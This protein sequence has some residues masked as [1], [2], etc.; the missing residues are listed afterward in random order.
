[1]EAGSVRQ[2]GDLGF[3][4]SSS[5]C[6][7]SDFLFHAASR[8]V[9]GL[10][11]PHIQWVTGFSLDKAAGAW[12]RQVRLV[13][14]LRMH[15]AIPPPSHASSWRW[16]VF[17]HQGQLAIGVSFLYEKYLWSGTNWCTLR[18]RAYALTQTVSFGNAVWIIW[19][20]NTCYEM[21]LLLNDV[22]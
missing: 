18:S 9:L 22:Y 1:M 14:S 6:T 19:H 4:L 20:W 15:G 10:T 7:D 3:E 8:P 5:A 21:Y 11:E 17:K 13:P 12:S 16:R 2:R